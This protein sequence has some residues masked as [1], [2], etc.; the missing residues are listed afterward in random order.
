M[1]NSKKTEKVR[2]FRSIKELPRHFQRQW[3]SILVFA[4][5][6]QLLMSFLIKP[7]SFGLGNS[8]LRRANIPSLRL[9]SLSLAAS[10]P[11]FWLVVFVGMV[12]FAFLMLFQL[13]S[14]V[15]L[16]STEHRTNQLWSDLG[17]V[18][19]RIRYMLLP[20]RLLLLLLML[21]ILIILGLTY[22]QTVLSGFQVPK[23]I[24]EH[25]FSNN[26]LAS[27]A[28][29]LALLVTYAGLRLAFVLHGF[30]SG[31]LGWRAALKQ[32]LRLTKR[33]SIR[34]LILIIIVQLITAFI[35]HVLRLTVLTVVYGIIVLTRGNQ[36]T[37]F[38]FS[39]MLGVSRLMRHFNLVML[40]AI[41]LAV[42]S[43]QY[44][45]LG[46]KISL[47][48]EKNQSK[49]INRKVRWVLNSSIVIMILLSFF[50][51]GHQLFLNTVPHGSWWNLTGH[52][53]IV[54]HRGSSRFA[55]ENTLAA[56][57]KAVE[58][59]AD[60]VEVDVQLTKD[61]HVVLFHDSTLQRIANRPERIKELDLAEIQEIDAGSW[62]DAKYNNEKIPTLSETLDTFL[63]YVNFNI[64][65]KPDGNSQELAHAVV[66]IIKERN[67]FR[68]CDLSSLDKQAILNAKELDD[69]VTIGIILPLITGNFQADDKMDYYS[70][71]TSQI[72]IAKL[73]EAHQLGRAVYVWTV[74]DNAD[75][76]KMREL[77]V[78]GVITDEPFLARKFLTETPFELGLLNFLD[79]SSD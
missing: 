9:D 27:L 65:L 51:I 19:R 8:I 71:E 57:R 48:Q 35:I 31:G 2:I 47:E 1:E 75:F 25:I 32:S 74:N 37:G 43:Q 78:D 13:S 62:F 38:D 22:N 53:E 6:F 12:G 52:V 21:P 39:L 46:G 24:Q 30:I 18:L 16:S 28:T 10:K 73:D 34:L 58:Q 11:L 77:Q 49:T 3:K 40:T 76:T 60:R 56:V 64:E 5:V 42:Q 68:Q 54:A 66:E 20:R 61:G 15:F 29:I 17:I 63:P 50:M 67:A 70:V 23:F 55:P 45:K 41:T 14:Y 26:T 59:R 33:Q 36:L 69:R 79:E 4:I 7:I 44:Q 72:S